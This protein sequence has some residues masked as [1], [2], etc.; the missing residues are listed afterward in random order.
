MNFK[1]IA[2]IGLLLCG[3]HTVNAEDGRPEKSNILLLLTD[4]LGW[5]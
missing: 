3:I 5:Q 4:D 1:W 2:A